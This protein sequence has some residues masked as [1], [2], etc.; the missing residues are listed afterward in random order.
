MASA[1]AEASAE[2]EVSEQLQNRTASFAQIKSQSKS[3][4]RSPVPEAV[5]GAA[6][7]ASEKVF[8]CTQ[9]SIDNF[10]IGMPLGR[11]KF[12]HV[13]LVREKV[14]KYVMTIKVLYKSQLLKCRMTEQL[15]REVE[16]HSH[17]RHKNVVQF[18][19]FFYDDDKIYLMLEYCPGGELYKNLKAQ[20]QGR[21][22]EQV[23]A[24]YIYQVIQA[25]KYIHS[26]DIIHR[27]IKPE[28]LLN[29]LGVIKLADYGW[30]VHAP[31]NRR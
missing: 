10:E 23:A 1:A 6:N 15:R 25:L 13:Y 8:D 24:G 14:S 4:S 31:S 20:P 28:N 22:S 3:R 5:R 12:G 9:W 19:G 18:Y 7:N 27:D 2:A 17:L 29:C 26:K 30:S 11:G 21:Y 16:I